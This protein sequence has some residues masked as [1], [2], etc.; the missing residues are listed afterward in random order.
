MLGGSTFMRGRSPII[1][2]SCWYG[3]H[4]LL[5]VLTD[6]PAQSANS[7]LVI[8]FI[9]LLFFVCSLSRRMPRFAKNYHTF[10]V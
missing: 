1:Q 2:S 7:C 5:S 4:Q 8:A 3:W 6:T 9:N 10:I